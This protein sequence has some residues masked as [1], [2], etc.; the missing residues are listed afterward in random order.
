MSNNTEYVRIITVVIVHHMMC[1]RD[2][3]LLAR[4]SNKNISFV[5]GS[6]II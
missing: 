6:N 1:M 3:M 5:V 4:G 2:G